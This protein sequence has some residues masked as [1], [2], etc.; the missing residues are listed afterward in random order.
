MRVFEF[1][2]DLPVYQPTHRESVGHRKISRV[3]VINHQRLEQT[4]K[5]A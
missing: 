1:V 2:S 3:F 5:N 4:K